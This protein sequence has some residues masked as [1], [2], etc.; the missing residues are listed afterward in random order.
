MASSAIEDN[1]FRKNNRRRRSHP[2]RVRPSNVWSR[3]SNRVLR[4]K[5]SHPRHVRPSN[6]PFRKSSRALR[7]KCSRSPRLN[8]CRRPRRSRNLGRTP[9]ATKRRTRIRKSHRVEPSSNAAARIEFDVPR[10]VRALC[11]HY[12]PGR[13][14][15]YVG[16]DKI[17][18]SADKINGALT[19]TDVQT[20]K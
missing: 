19:I 7:R 2:R 11:K 12:F 15:K 17:K 3:K 20:S 16:S 8:P 18:F 13:R 10:N 6:V 14:T 5:G 4:R 9:S 1:P